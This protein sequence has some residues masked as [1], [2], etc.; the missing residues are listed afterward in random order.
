MKKTLNMELILQI[1]IIL[2]CVVII[3]F[4]FTNESVKAQA[5]CGDGIPR[6]R[7]ETSP[8]RYSWAQGAT[9]SVVIFD[10]PNPTDFNLLNDGI[11]SWDKDS[12]PNCSFVDFVKAIPAT[13]QDQTQS[14]PDDTMWV[15]RPD[16]PNGELVRF[17]RNPGLPN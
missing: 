1:S 12:F 4:Q 13:N 7:D 17:Y 9:V 10:T 14:P 6:Y 11:Q 8:K 15:L 5:V 2:S 3:M 16:T